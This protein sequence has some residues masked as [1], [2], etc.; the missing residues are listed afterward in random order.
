MRHLKMRGLAGFSGQTAMT[1][2]LEVTIAQTRQAPPMAP[3]PSAASSKR[4]N[5]R[6]VSQSGTLPERNQVDATYTLI[7]PTA[8]WVSS[9]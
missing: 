6:A 8:L 9:S 5:G 4:S 2:L 7:S 1:C 3:R